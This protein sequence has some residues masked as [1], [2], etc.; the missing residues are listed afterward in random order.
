MRLTMVSKID[1]LGSKDKEIKLKVD[2]M[3]IILI[4]I[5]RLIS[6]LNTNQ[7][8]SKASIT[9]VI[10]KDNNKN[11]LMKFINTKRKVKAGAHIH[12]TIVHTCTH[13]CTNRIIDLIMATNTLK[14]KSQK[15]DKD[16][17]NILQFLI[18]LIRLLPAIFHRYNRLTHNRVR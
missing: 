4:L 5:I 7:S 1:S 12:I 6:C 13:R 11:K 2:H 8:K 16:H 18:G 15:M 17:T 14:K 9:R 10:K 3:V